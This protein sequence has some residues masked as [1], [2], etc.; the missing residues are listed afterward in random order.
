MAPLPSAAGGGPR[1]CRGAGAKRRLEGRGCGVMRSL[2]LILLALLAA[3]APSY[4]RDVAFS[5]LPGWAADIDCDGWA[6]VALKF[7]VS[8]PAVTCAIPATTRIDHVQENLG[9]ASGPLP[10]AA[11]RARMIAHVE[12]L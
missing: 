10:D 5:D 1:R 8:H 2:S 12:T 4:P 3:C 7:I 11:I 6:Q 9:A